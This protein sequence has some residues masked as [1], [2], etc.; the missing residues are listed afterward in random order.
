MSKEPGFI[1]TEAGQDSFWK[2]PMLILSTL[3]TLC[4]GL[5]KSLGV[6]HQFGVIPVRHELVSFLIHKPDF[7]PLFLDVSGQDCFQHAVVE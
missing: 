7:R 3:M 2:T 1:S 4:W 6:S 5:P